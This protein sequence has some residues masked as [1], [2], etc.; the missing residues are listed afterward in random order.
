V[1]RILAS[2]LIMGAFLPVV[3]GATAGGPSMLPVLPVAFERRPSGA[4]TTRAGVPVCAVLQ[5][6]VASLHIW[7]DVSA[8][9]DRRESCGKGKYG[10]AA[11]LH[12]STS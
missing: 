5:L 1:R 9:P 6:N 2:S 3:A 7:D 4:R 12:M 11:M 10:T 8:T